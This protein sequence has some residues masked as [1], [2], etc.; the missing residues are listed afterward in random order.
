MGPAF[1]YLPDQNGVILI[2]VTF[3]VSSAITVA[4]TD[5]RANAGG[6]RREERSPSRPPPEDGDGVG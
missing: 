5:M 3:K 2:H 4:Q 1:T 6:Q